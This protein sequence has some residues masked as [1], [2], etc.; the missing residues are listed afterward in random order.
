MLIY[1]HGS[2]WVEPSHRRRLAFDGAD[3]FCLMAAQGLA[4]RVV[5]LQWDD[6][7]WEV[8]EVATKDVGSIVDGVACPVEAFAISWWGVKGSLELLDS[9][10]QAG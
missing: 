1:A 2:V 10:F 8:V 6:G 4:E 7:F 3:C 9:L 5:V